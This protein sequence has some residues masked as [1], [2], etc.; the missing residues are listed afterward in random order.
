M[1]T[2]HGI[3][4]ATQ[5]P[6]LKMRVLPWAEAGRLDGQRGEGKRKKEEKHGAKL[7]S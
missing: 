1:P 7:V 5:V 3:E 2:G 4:G 6:V